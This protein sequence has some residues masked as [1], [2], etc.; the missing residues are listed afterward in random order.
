MQTLAE[1]INE[2]GGVAEAARRLG[3]SRQTLD[4][5]QTG[6]F[7]PSRVMVELAKLKGVDLESQLVIP[8]A[9]NL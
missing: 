4:R 6:K 9:E 3:V 1:F 7:K 8:G 5:W 2:S